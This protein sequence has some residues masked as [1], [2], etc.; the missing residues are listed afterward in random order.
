MQKTSIV[1]QHTATRTT[2]G[3]GVDLFETKSKHAAEQCMATD[4]TPQTG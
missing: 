1:Q 4:Y 3:V 2:P